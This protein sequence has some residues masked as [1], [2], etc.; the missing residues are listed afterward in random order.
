[1]A[2]RLMSGV[3]DA[4]RDRWRREWRP[5]TSPKAPENV[6]NSEE[7]EEASGPEMAPMMKDG[8]GDADEE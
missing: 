6:T 7:D 8:V 3:D 5:Q 1:M 4:D 2:L